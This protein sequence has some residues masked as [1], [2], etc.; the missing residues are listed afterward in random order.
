MKES[1]EKAE[2]SMK[3]IPQAVLAQIYRSY[4]LILINNI[5]FLL[6]FKNN[7]KLKNL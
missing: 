4:Q 5:R 7:K 3:E 1:N 2:K 6:F